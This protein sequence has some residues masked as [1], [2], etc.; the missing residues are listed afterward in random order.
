MRAENEQLTLES[1][2]PKRPL[3]LP[4]LLCVGCANRDPASDPPCAVCGA[5][6]VDGV[7]IPF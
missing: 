5:D 3:P 6:V 4:F 2:P 7:G 1:E